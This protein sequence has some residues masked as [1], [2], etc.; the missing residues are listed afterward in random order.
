VDYVEAA[1]AVGGSDRGSDGD[2]ASCPRNEAARSVG[3]D[4]RAENPDRG[5][6]TSTAGDRSKRRPDAS[7]RTDAKPRSVNSTGE[8]RTTS[9]RPH[10]LYFF[11]DVPTI[12]D[13]RMLPGLIPN[14]TLP[15]IRA[16]FG[17]SSA[18]RWRKRRFAIVIKHATNRHVQEMQPICF[19]INN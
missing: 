3:G 16:W 7:G 15:K 17:M 19:I 6:S 18:R 5:A 2:D 11:S 8:A 13:V 4:D 9:G 10:S 12:Y 14:H 1:A